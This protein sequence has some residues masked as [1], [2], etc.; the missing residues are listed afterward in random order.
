MQ[1]RGKEGRDIGLQ[2]GRY[3][4][5]DARSAMDE[6]AA[7]LAHNQAELNRLQRHAQKERAKLRKQREN[8]LLTATIA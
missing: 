4:P 5:P 8:A 3:F 7:E 6:V 1:S 2:R